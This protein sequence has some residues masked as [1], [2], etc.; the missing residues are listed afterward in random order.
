MIS[1]PF[2][3]GIMKN[4]ISVSQFFFIFLISTGLSNHVLV[5]P[6]LIDAA[7]R[8]AWI[9]VFVGYFISIPFLLLM[10]YVTKHFKSISIFEWLETNYNKAFRRIIAVL[11]SI[12]LFITGFI[13]LKETVT[14]THETYLQDTPMLVVGISILATSLYISYGKLNVIAICAGVLL[15]FVVLFGLLVTIGTIPNKNYSL[16]TPVLVENG[17]V[18]IIN[19]SIF[20]FGSLLEIF[21]LIMIQHEIA[22]RVTF[23]HIL[24]LSFFLFILTLGPLIGSIAVFGADE[25]G[26]LRYPAF[27]QWRILNIGQYFNHV[28]FLSIYQWLSG[29]FIRLALIL[30]LITRAFPF[31]KKKQRIIAQA[32]ICILYLMLV[33]APISDEHFSL[34][35]KDYF[36]PGTGAFAVVMI[37]FLTLLIKTSKNGM[38]TD[39]K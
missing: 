2:R 22:R 31:K 6:L 9:S 34:F 33:L 35:L 28:D 13:T 19:G 27:L 10:V 25:A 21:L 20:V 5:I 36:Y 26:R 16:I 23:K 29:S 1:T 4:P 15:P 37:L 38:E 39:E 12:F 17:W 11:I 8:D 30:Y 7:G 14:W 18:D 3:G 24:L 32:V